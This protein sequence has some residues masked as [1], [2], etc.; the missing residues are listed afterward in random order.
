MTTPPPIPLPGMIPPDG[1]DLDDDNSTREPVG[2]SDVE[3][4]KARTGADRD[5]D[6]EPLIPDDEPIRD[7]DGVPVGRADA[8]ADARRAGADPDAG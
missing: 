2:A 8:E 3:A 1:D 5:E 4:D 7:S 6:L